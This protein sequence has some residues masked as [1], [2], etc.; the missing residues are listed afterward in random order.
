MRTSLV[1]WLTLTS[2]LPSLAAQTCGAG[3]RLLKN[4][5]LPDN[6]SG[7]YTI[8]IVPGLCDNE[9]AMSLFNAGGP[10]KVKSVGIGYGHRFSTNGVQ[11]LVDIEIYDGATVAANGRWTL[12]PLLFRLS[13]GSTNLQI[14]ST[15]INIATLPVPVRVPSGR[16]VIGFRMLMNLAGG[17]CLQGYDANFFCDAENRCR[18]GINI[19]DATGHGPVD[20]VTYTGFGV[21]LCPVFFRGSWV[22]R[23]CIEPEI[24]VEWQGTPT[25]GGVLSV[26]YIAPNRAGDNYLA[27]A[28]G[29]FMNGGFTSPF[30]H[31]PL[32][33]DPLFFC[34]LGDCRSM[35]IGSLGVIGQNDRAFGGMLI[36]NLSVLRN[37]GLTLYLAFVLFG[38][39]LNF[40]GES[41]P[42]APIVIN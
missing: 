28:G 33:P 6:P 39:T 13:S 30:G 41:S 10:C 19:L 18:A 17:S 7:A 24:S 38:Q 5:I 29:S 12:G 32:D 4:D 22:I 8:G 27:L 21:G 23:A 25:P 26:T 16:P 9:A 14:Q 35:L 34:F 37:S 15:G 40:T 20:P 31:V 36:P 42:S 11:A 3:E 1:A 2:L